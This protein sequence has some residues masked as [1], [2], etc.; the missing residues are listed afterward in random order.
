[1]RDLIL[2]QEWIK[3]N[4][5]DCVNLNAPILLDQI[6][7]DAGFRQYF[8]IN[9]K[10]SLI[11]VFSPPAT[12][13]NTSFVNISLCF[14]KNHIRSP[15][16]YAVDYELGFLLLEDFGDDLL[17]PFL[18]GRRAEK[19]YACAEKELIKIQKISQSEIILPEYN[20]QLLLEEIGL[21]KEWFLKK[22][23]KIQL[24]K[25][26][27]DLLDN[28]FS[29]IIKSAL[30]QS[31]VVVHRDFHSRNLMKL[32]D[33]SIGVIDFQDA[34]IGPLTYDVVSLFR[35]CYIR[36]PKDFVLKKTL[37]FYK[38][39]VDLGITTE[40]SDHK[41]ISWLDMMGL[42]RHLK[43]LGVFSRLYL[44][45]S[46]HKYLN[47]LPLVIRYVMEELEPYSN[48]KDFSRWFECKVLS[49][50][51]RQSWYRSWETAGE[52]REKLN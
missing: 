15:F 2:F 3:G 48:L 40:A 29:I 10:P 9:S 33:R 17:A 45:D 24:N 51:P 38:R 46:K 49:E 36:L 34:V 6:N 12:E 25:S 39:A 4:L 11:A 18:A 7:S 41:V 43:V 37:R 21:F 16:V 50:L 1:M 27:E 22:L 26:D 31:Q 19:F 14:K 42:Q 47:D 32:S 44:R 35:D 5:P 52:V 23:L 30:Q 20:Q 8:R 13:N 28:A